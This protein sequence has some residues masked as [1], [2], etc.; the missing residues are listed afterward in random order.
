MEKRPLGRTD[1]WITPVGFGSWA[2]GGAGWEF[3]WG[4]QDDRESIAAIHRALDLGVNWID[5]AAIYGLGHSEEIVG[6]AIAGREPRPLVFT[7]CSMLWDDQGKISR[8]LKADSI[9]RELENS[10]RRL[11]LDTIDLYQLHWPMP[12]DQLEEGW[13]TLSELKRE[14]KVRYIGASNFNVAQLERARTIAPVDSL[15][16]PYS[17][18]RPQ[19]EIEVLPYCLEHGIGVIVYAPMMSGLLTGTMSHERAANFPPDDWRRRNPEFQEPRLSRNLG[20]ADLLGQIAGRHGRTAG[21][22]AIAWTLRNPAV[23]G[24]IVGARRPEQVEGVV[25]AADFRLSPEELQE[26]DHFVQGNAAQ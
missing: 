25:G 26:I 7:K 12:E 3:A 18:V 17:L 16:P 9:R 13:A 5:T 19:V 20:L 21:E 6:Q 24:A 2:A 22:A 8:S 1:L 14:G 10:L 11:K 4:P 23:N 15:Q